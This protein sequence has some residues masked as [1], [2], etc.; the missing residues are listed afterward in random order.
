MSAD[1]FGRFYIGL[2]YTDPWR[3]KLIRLHCHDHLGVH[4][5][6]WNIAYAVILTDETKDE[7]LRS[8]FVEAREAVRMHVRSGGIVALGD[9]ST[10]D[11]LLD[12]VQLVLPRERYVADIYP[13]A[14]RELFIENYLSLGKFEY[15]V[16][17]EQARRGYID[18]YPTVWVTEKYL[19]IETDFYR[20]LDTSHTPD[21]LQNLPLSVY[22]LAASLWALLLEHR[23]W[24]TSTAEKIRTFKE[25]TSRGYWTRDKNGDPK[26][27]ER[28]TAG[29]VRV[30]RAGDACVAKRVGGRQRSGRLARSQVGLEEQS[31]VPWPVLLLIV[32]QHVL[33]Q[34]CGL[35]GGRR[36]HERAAVAYEGLR[37]YI[38]VS[39]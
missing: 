27:S 11:R 22:R 15:R 18:E 10:A 35:Q 39:Q 17:M 30:H 16:V 23:N 14:P 38:L 19:S 4:R 6:L 21:H 20:L 2:N 29:H 13:S 31:H 25:C 9:Q 7:F 3:D 5:V 32:R 33:P 34:E 1:V 26:R 12:G 28:G 37:G 24:S 8:A 36:L